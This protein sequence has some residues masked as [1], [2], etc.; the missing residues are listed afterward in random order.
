MNPA[1]A[2]LPLPALELRDG[3]PV[4]SA[5][6]DVYFSRAGGMAETEHVFLKGNGLPERW[7]AIRM[8]A[9][10]IAELGFGTGLNFLVTLR[11]FRATA[12]ATA[13]L[14][15]VS[16]EKFPF[17]PAVLKQLLA[18][19]P[20]LSGEAAELLAAYPMRLPG[21]HRLH[22]GRVTL[23]LCFGDVQE[24]LPQLIW[25]QTAPSQ[26]SAL[27]HEGMHGSIDAWYLD[28]FSPAKNPEMWG[29][30]IYQ[31][32]ARMSAPGATFATFTAASH[33]RRGLAAVGFTVTKQPGF[34]HKRE[35]SKGIFEG[36]SLTP[37]PQKRLTPAA[38]TAQSNMMVV[39]GGIAGATL[40]RAMA[41]RGY[42]VTV[43]ERAE[44]AS[45]ASGNAAGVLFPQITKHW[46]TAS[47]WYFA[48][49]SYALGQIARWHAEGLTFEHA[50][51]G[52]LRLPRNPEEAQWLTQLSDTH[53]LDT[54]IVHWLTCDEASARAGVALPTGAAFF[55]HGTW[56]NPG[57]L[58]NALLQHEHITLRTQAM[59]EAINRD[60]D[61]WR[62]TLAGDEIVKAPVCCITAA[63]ESAAW[64][65]AYGITLGHVGGQIS[66]F[67]RGDAGAPLSSILCHSG[68]VIPKAQHLLVGA[69]YHRED[70][71]AVTA[72][73]H[74]QNQAALAAIVPTMPLREAVGG[75]SAIRATTGD[76]MPII[77]AI[78]EGLYVASGFGS[79]GL[80]SAPLAAEMIASHVVGEAPPVAHALLAA[81]N[82]LR[83]KKRSTTP[84][85]QSLHA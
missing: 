35:M 68:Y 75:R 41:E 69:T 65:A 43:L 1:T 66:E 9:F 76:R 58:C 22:F 21:L 17:T 50:R 13:R 54:E 83:F 27:L 79:R 47:A 38:R 20:E 34:G 84:H 5:F 59:V 61:G 6:E 80:L 19:H 10:T 18:F 39:G 48:A 71:L 85:P 46:S 14:H 31:Q 67:P 64:L 73:R 51:A 42:S 28:G 82:P 32:V 25:P 55:P 24:I 8:H 62:I 29:D 70:M 81:V 23:T 57:Q 3:L 45:G 49:Y 16:I 37:S 15:Y 52:M 56:L 12:P 11:A 60:G 63:Y 44:V 7:M 53:G 78:D 77:G 40:A 72:Q 2:H 74:A 26:A 33:V 4:S 30:A 36:V